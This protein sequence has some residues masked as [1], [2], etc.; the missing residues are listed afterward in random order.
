MRCER[1]TAARPSKTNPF[2]RK[3][4]APAF[5]LRRLPGEEPAFPVRNRDA[6]GAEGWPLRRLGRKNRSKDRPLQ[7]LGPKNRSK[8]RPL[9]K[10]GPKNRSKDRP[11]H[12]EGASGRR[13]AWGVLFL[14]WRGET[15]GGGEI[16]RL[17]G[18]TRHSSACRRESGRS[19]Q[20]DNKKERRDNR[21]QAG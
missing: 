6:H 8:D 16:L 2:S 5:H 17:R 1:S 14:G 3:S 15:E 13:K 20:D 7:R 19:A 10:L 9:Q 18:P 21:R 11:L 4:F 12:G